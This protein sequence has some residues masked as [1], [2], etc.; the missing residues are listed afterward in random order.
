MRPRKNGPQWE[1]R[2]LTAT[3]VLL[4]CFVCPVLETFDH[5]DHAIQTGN[6][7]EYPL[8]ALALCVGAAYSCAR[9]MLLLR[10]IETASSFPASG[11][12]FFPC[13][14]VS[15]YRSLVRQVHLLFRCE[16]RN[17]R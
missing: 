14:V 8:V 3:L 12:R 4:V 9:F 10:F 13:I 7:T 1:W 15:R 17:H 5:W 2:R 16:S 6:D 11:V